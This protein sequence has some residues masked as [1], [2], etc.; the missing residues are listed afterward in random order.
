MIKLLSIKLVQD[1]AFPWIYQRKVQ[2]LRVSLVAE[3][4]SG[5][6]AFEYHREAARCT[7]VDVLR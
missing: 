1:Q 3:Y 5:R 7:W 6:A 4:R 2:H